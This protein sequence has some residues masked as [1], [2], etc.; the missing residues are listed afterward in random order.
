MHHAIRAVVL[1]GD[2]VENVANR[3]DGVVDVDPHGVVGL[4]FDLL[5]V[6]QVTE[7]DDRDW[8]RAAVCEFAGGE[9]AQVR[10]QD[11]RVAA[12]QRFPVFADGEVGVV[13]GEEIEGADDDDVLDPGLGG[14]P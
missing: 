7:A 13:G 9:F 6:D 12:G 4:A 5:R 8:Q 1:G 3:A 10:A 2:F 14:G 11:R